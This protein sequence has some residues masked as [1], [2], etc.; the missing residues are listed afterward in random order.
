LQLAYDRNVPTLNASKGSNVKSVTPPE[1]PKSGD[2]RNHMQ[3]TIEGGEKMAIR[4]DI[5]EN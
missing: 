1:R 5:W 2:A 3:I 4:W